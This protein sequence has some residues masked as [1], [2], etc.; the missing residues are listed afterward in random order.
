M[1]S[2]PAQYAAANYIVTYVLNPD[3]RQQVRTMTVNL[4]HARLKGL[5]D[6]EGA[7]RIVATTKGYD[8]KDV[9]LLALAQDA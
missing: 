6:A 8:L 1:T 3:P 5:E 7:R 4:T 9:C 2:T